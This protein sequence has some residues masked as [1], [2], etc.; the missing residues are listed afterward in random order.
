MQANIIVVFL[1]YRDTCPYVQ[2]TLSSFFMSQQHVMPGARQEVMTQNINT[3][4]KTYL[5]SLRWTI[6]IRGTLNLLI[7]LSV[8]KY[9][10]ASGILLVIWPS[11]S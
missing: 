9:I 8:E 11:K 10:C 6:F 5:T 3:E 1:F 4:L 2:D 7:F